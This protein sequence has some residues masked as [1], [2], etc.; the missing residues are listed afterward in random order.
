MVGLPPLNPRLEL[1][2]G[3]LLPLAVEVEE[4]LSFF[5]GVGDLGTLLVC[6]IVWE[7]IEIVLEDVDCFV[8]LEG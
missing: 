6:L 7:N 3:D 5:D 4:I 2:A 8:G 1:D